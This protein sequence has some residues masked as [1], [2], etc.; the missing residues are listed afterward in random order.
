MI[1]LCKG[2]EKVTHYLL[3]ELPIITSPEPLSSQVK[4][5]KSKVSIFFFFGNFG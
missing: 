4:E 5:Q 2:K 1:V 3:S